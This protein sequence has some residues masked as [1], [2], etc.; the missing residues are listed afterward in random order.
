MRVCA[1]VKNIELTYSIPSFYY[2]KYSVLYS[3]IKGIGMGTFQN[4]EKRGRRVATF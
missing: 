4:M 1:T 3:R 2:K